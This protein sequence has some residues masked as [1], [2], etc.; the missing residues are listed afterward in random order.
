MNAIAGFDADAAPAS[1]P[2]LQADAGEI[3]R[4]VNALF[5]YAEPDTFVSLRAFDQFDRN[6]KPVFITGHKLTAAGLQPLIGAA[7][8]AAQKTADHPNAAVFAPPICTFSHNWRAKGADLAAGLTL[9]VEI[10]GPEPNRPGPSPSLAGRDWKVCSARQPWLLNPD[11]NG[12]TPR[13]ARLNRR[14]TC[15]GACL[16]RPRNMPTMTSCGRRVQSPCA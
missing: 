2:K 1:A 14:F 7:A 12:R 4:F 16:S 5:R 11:R 6:A 15:T 10:D 13:P 8:R 3:D 9:S